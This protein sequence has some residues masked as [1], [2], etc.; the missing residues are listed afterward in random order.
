MSSDGFS[1]P[2]TSTVIFPEAKNTDITVHKF[3]GDTSTEEK[4]E[5]INKWPQESIRKT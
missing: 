3:C 5:D 2:V 1:V 4:N